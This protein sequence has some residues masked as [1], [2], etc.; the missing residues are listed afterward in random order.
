MNQP[1]L[2]RYVLEGIERRGRRQGA[3]VVTFPQ[4]TISVEGESIYVADGIR[5]LI[6]RTSGFY[7]SLPANAFGVVVFPNGTSHNMEGGVHDVPPGLYRL[8]YVDKHERLDHSSPISE[9]TTDGEKL[10]LKVV[11]RYRV[12][13]P[14]TALRID[15][16]IENI[17][18]HVEA[19]I[20]QYIRTHDHSDIADSA[21]QN[22]DSKLLSF[23]IQRHN[24]RFPLSKAFIITG[25]ELKE[26]F[27]DDEYVEMRRKASTEKRKNRIEKEQ[28]ALQQE[29][30][31]I[32]AQYQVANEKSIA[33]HN[34]ELARKAAEHMVEMGKLEARYEKEK[35][36]IMEQV[37]LNEIELDDRRKHLQRRENEFAKAVDAIS[38]AISSGYTNPVVVKTIADLAAALK[39]DVNSEYRPTSELSESK[40]STNQ[41]RIATPPISPAEGD[42]VEKLTNTL[43]GLLNSKR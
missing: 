39:E 38:T 13:D 12:V 6:T 37:H 21:E 27:G 41:K 19:D 15:R 35:Q 28:A 34:A 17:I 18:E 8:H 1:F 43:L 9:L 40:L 25:I 2:R 5:F 7:L 42:R 14:I 10:T 36:E 22:Q 3:P 30:N 31:L 4:R 23:F 16:P 29:L 26:F 32:K 24:R 11:L 20:A 33:D